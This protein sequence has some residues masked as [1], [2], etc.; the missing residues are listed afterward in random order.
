MHLFLYHLLLLL[1][2]LYVT[3]LPPCVDIIAGGGGATTLEAIRASALSAVATAFP[4][5]TIAARPNSS[6]VYVAG[7]GSIY[8]RLASNDVI[9]VAGTAT[10]TLTA[11]MSIDTGISGLPGPQTPLCGSEN[12]IYGFSFSPRDGTLYFISDK[13]IRSLTTDGLVHLIAGAGLTSSYGDNGIALLAKFNVLGSTAVHTSGDIYISDY[14]AHTIRCIRYITGIIELIAGIPD[15]AGDDGDEGLAI[16]AKLI[17]PLGLVISPD[18][19]S[20][21]IADADAHRIRQIDLNTRII[22]TFCGTGFVPSSSSS[23][24]IGEN[25]LAIAASIS[26]PISLAIDPVMNVLYIA[27][28]VTNSIQRVGLDTNIINRVAGDGSSQPSSKICDGRGCIAKSISI[29][30]PVAITVDRDGRLLILKKDSIVVQFVSFFPR[31]SSTIGMLVDVDPVQGVSV[32][33]VVN[34]ALLARLQGP[35]FIE[36]L[37]DGS[38][39]LV[40]YSGQRL[41]RLKTDGSL[42]LLAGRS[43]NATSSSSIFLDGT[44]LFELVLRRPSGIV[45]LPQGFAFGRTW[46]ALSFALSDEGGNIVYGIDGALPTSKVYRLV[47]SANRSADFSGD[48]GL[49]LNAKLKEPRGLLIDVIDSSL[50]IID[51]GNNRIRK[52]TTNTPSTIST[53]AGGGTGTFFIS[54]DGDGLSATSAPLYAMY[55]FCQDLIGNTL[56]PDL[57]SNVIRKIDRNGIITTLVGRST[58]PQGGFGGD[59]GIPALASLNS[60]LS[61]ARDTDGGILITDAANG[62]IRKINPSMTSITTI[63]GGGDFST[64]GVHPLKLKLDFSTDVRRSISGDILIADFGAGVIRRVLFSARATP[65]PA[66]YSCTCI[67]AR[68]CE[69]INSFCPL[70]STEPLIVS[71]GYKSISMQQGVEK[72]AVFIS[73]EQCPIG[74]YC[75]GNSPAIECPAGTYGSGTL[76]ISLQACQ[77]CPIGSY[78]GATGGAARFL[79]ISKSSKAIIPCLP[80]PAG[81][82]ASISGSLYCIP[83]PTGTFTFFIQHGAD[84]ISKCLPCPS[85]EI[86]IFGS[87]CIKRGV[88]TNSDVIIIADL[89]LQFQRSIDINSISGNLSGSSA[90]ARILYIGA[91]LA[92]ISFFFVL[93]A[94]ILPIL[95]LDNKIKQVLVPVL[96]TLDVL[97]DPHTTVMQKIAVV[98]KSTRNIALIQKNKII[99]N[100]EEQENKQDTNEI[101]NIHLNDTTT[102]LSQPKPMPIHYLYHEYSRL[103][104]TLSALTLGLLGCIF[105]ANAVLFANRNIT[106]LSSLQ[107][108]DPSDISNYYTAFPTYVLKSDESSSSTTTG[109]L[110]NGSITLVN[111]LG[112][113]TSGLLINVKTSGS[114]CGAIYNMFFDLNKGSFIHSVRHNKETGEASHSFQCRSCLTHDLSILRF[115]LNSACEASTVITISAVGAWGSIT[116]TSQGLGGKALGGSVFLTVPI[117]FEVLSDLTDSDFSDQVSDTILAVGQS[118]KGLSVGAVTDF[119]QRPSDI[120]QLQGDISNLSTTKTVQFQ[121]FLPNQPTYLFASLSKRT[122]WPDFISNLVGLAGFV[123]LGGIVYMIIDSITSLCTCCHVSRKL[124]NNNDQRIV[125]SR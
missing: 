87:P 31:L 71:A 15:I 89:R 40:E 85:N 93:L 80:C 61:C 32:A 45:S 57:G 117:T 50:L 21:F 78:F 49:A 7:R 88:S 64:P 62:R 3:A 12:C 72:K 24:F 99:V 48:G 65:C 4:F 84:S 112:G 59:T 30:I 92:F 116:A 75:P 27:D 103:G 125:P 74:T 90:F 11:V 41:R 10:T 82:Y 96:N 13:Y 95:S 28:T 110:S 54:N 51:S 79:D 107:R 18:G 113:L 70:G 6:D 38:I 81:S 101:A 29:P 56:V 34:D 16:N 124:N 100:T 46:S 91:A 60:P 35:G 109:L 119:F 17:T 98:S 20:L 9:Q 122:L 53:L 118:A 5:T 83:C 86:T 2:W 14:G 33:S 22:T 8:L 44:L 73:Q 120:M 104:V 115:E 77:K 23:P 108:S 63:V 123:P 111:A 52:V 39:L 69:D 25:G 66:G 26:F 58:S 114:L 1:S 105:V 19:R 102:D 97:S 106:V 37:S 42:I 36:E 67:I 43:T 55:S 121:I 47:G 76:E 94:A 68:P